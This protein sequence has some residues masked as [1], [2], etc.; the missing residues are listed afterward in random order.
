VASCG[1][2][3]EPVVPRGCS[4]VFM[5]HLLRIERC[6]DLPGD[7]L[8]ERAEGLFAR[9]V[10]E[11]FPQANQKDP[12]VPKRGG[13]RSSSARMDHLPDF[14]RGTAET[15]RRDSAG[16]PLILPGARAKVER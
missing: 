10:W 11:C 13:T 4:M 6:V 7:D 14:L 9:L 12:L 8:A 5:P 15:K 2:E 1:C 16:P 3:T